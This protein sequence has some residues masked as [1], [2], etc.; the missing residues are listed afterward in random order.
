M[1]N[2]RKVTVRELRHEFPKV[3]AWVEAGETVQVTK[4]GKVV[5]RYTSDSEEVATPPK[6]PDFAAR[7]KR[8]CGDQKL[9]G[10]TWAELIREERD[11]RW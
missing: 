8:I 4:R 11:S 3:Q 6:R 2:M 1:Y 7:M 5:G 10:T 9:E